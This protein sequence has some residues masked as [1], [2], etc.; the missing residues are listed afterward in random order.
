MLWKIKRG[1]RRVFRPWFRSDIWERRE[2][3]GGLGSK[4]FKLQVFWESF[5]EVSASWNP[6]AKDAHWR[7][8]VLGR[9]GP[10]LVFLPYS[11]TGWEQPKG[12]MDAVSPNLDPKVWAAR[13]CQSPV[14]LW[15]DSLAGKPE[16][17][18]AM[19]P[20]GHNAR[21]D[22]P[23]S[24]FSAGLVTGVVFHQLKEHP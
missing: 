3:E 18:T 6:W 21:R 20:Y 4:S 7:S 14:I 8:P 24:K 1:S 5:S 16:W 17:Y 19:D 15:A 9:N 23:E 13:G 11:I 22:L 12:S 10:L 2:K